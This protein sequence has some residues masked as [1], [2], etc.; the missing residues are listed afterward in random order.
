MTFDDIH[1]VANKYIY[2]HLQGQRSFTHHVG[3]NEANFFLYC[4]NDDP[5][6][7]LNELKNINCLRQEWSATDWSEFEVLQVKRAET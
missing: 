2:L 3:I 1:Y 6:D 4:K 5:I 7:C